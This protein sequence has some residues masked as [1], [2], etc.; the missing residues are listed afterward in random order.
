MQQYFG[1]L[2][3][4]RDRSV[5]DEIVSK[6]NNYVADFEKFDKTKLSTAKGRDELMRLY[7]MNMSKF[8]SD[9]LD[10]MVAPYVVQTINN[11]GRFNESG[12]FTIYL[13]N[14]TGGWWTKNFGDCT[15]GASIH[16]TDTV[17]DRNVVE[18]AT[19]E[20]VLLNNALHT[21]VKDVSDTFAKKAGLKLQFA[22][23]NC[24]SIKM[25]YVKK[26]N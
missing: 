2:Y 7:A 17:I 22:N 11:D 12:R 1:R 13:L 8:M 18:F 16:V 20:Y 6:N 26:E 4:V 24:D 25:H 23:E 14:G 19:G 21:A 3:V 5:L 15:I 10:M 9:A